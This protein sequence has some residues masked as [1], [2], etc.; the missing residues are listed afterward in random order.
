MR[1][2]QKA[3]LDEL[4]HVRRQNA[5]YAGE[6][7]AGVEDLKAAVCG[8]P[9]G[10][11]HV[12]PYSVSH[13]DPMQLVREAQRTDWIGRVTGRSNTTDL[14]TFVGFLKRWSWSG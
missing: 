2:G 8:K 12:H 6:R 3:L 13:E 10:K 7:P 14:S 1:R 9:V 4:R 11:H 5:E